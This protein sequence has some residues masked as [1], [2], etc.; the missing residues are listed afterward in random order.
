MHGRFKCIPKCCPIGQI[1]I[2]WKDGINKIS[3]HETSE[4]YLFCCERFNYFKQGKGIDQMLDEQRAKA[5]K[6]REIKIKNNSY[7]KT[8]YLDVEYSCT[9]EYCFSRTS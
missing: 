5:A 4:V 3:R 6:E 8:A 2:D 7:S 9:T 1:S